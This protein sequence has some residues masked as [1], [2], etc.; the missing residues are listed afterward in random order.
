MREKDCFAEDPCPGINML[1]LFSLLS[2]LSDPPPSEQLLEC[3]RSF[4]E[5]LSE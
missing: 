5:L 4:E 2:S 1:P 3:R